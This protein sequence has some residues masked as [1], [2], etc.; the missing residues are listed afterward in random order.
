MSRSCL[1]ST[2]NDKSNLYFVNFFRCKNS[3]WSFHNFNIGIPNDRSN[4]I[5]SYRFI[6]KNDVKRAKHFFFHI[7]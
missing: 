1:I 5:F 3:K 7:S 4:L 6:A 2:V